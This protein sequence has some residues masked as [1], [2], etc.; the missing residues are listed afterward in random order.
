MATINPVGRNLNKASRRSAGKRGSASSVV[1]AAINDDSPT[2]QWI[3]KGK[4][5]ECGN[6]ATVDMR[7]SI[8]ISRKKAKGSTSSGTSSNPRQWAK[9]EDSNSSLVAVKPSLLKRFYE[10]LVMLAVL[11][12]S[13][14][15]RTE[16]EE[17]DSELEAS[18]LGPD[19]LRRS[20]IRHLAYLCDYEK[21]GDRTTAIALEQ[22]PQGITYWLASNE[23]QYKRSTGADRTEA[24]LLVILQILGS[25]RDRFVH[26]VEL[27]IFEEAVSF[28]Q[29]RILKYSKFLN[30]N[31]NL[32][33]KYLNPLNNEKGKF[34]VHRLLTLN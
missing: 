10:A 27:A 7:A 17:L 1:G 29:S 11:G 16:E 24:F 21:G 22:T 4:G 23:T 32:V 14:G 12:K 30:N 15:D 33:L 3:S 13:R 9:P 6:S 28:S 26:Q 5:K 8:E 20:F 18:D 31:L 2:R 25:S 34:R 19:K